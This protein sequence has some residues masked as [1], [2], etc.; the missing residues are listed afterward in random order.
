MGNL[1]YAQS[2]RKAKKAYDNK[3]TKL[4]IG[5]TINAEDN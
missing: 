5:L 1:T 3:P 4:S 2:V